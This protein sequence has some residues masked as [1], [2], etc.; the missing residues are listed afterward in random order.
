MKVILINPTEVVDMAM[1]MKC[2]VWYPMNTEHECAPTELEEKRPCGESQQPS[3]PFLLPP[4]S[5]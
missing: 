2:L 5:E 3:E 1:C 4:A